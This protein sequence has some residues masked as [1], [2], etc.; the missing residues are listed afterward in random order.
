MSATE[1]CV[2]HSRDDYEVSCTE[3]DQLVKLALEVEGVYGSRMTGGGFGGCTV[4]LVKKSAVEKLTG[5]I[6]VH[7]V[8]HTLLLVT[9]IHTLHPGLSVTDCINLT[10]LMFV[11]LL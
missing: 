9:Y 3:L 2:F 5:H 10:Y 4:T 11:M 8:M 6:K 7:H 1:R